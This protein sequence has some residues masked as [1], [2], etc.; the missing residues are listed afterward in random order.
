MPETPDADPKH[1]FDDVE[2][3]VSCVLLLLDQIDSVCMHIVNTGSWS[4]FS[5]EQRARLSSVHQGTRRAI[6]AIHSPHV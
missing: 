2:E 4:T 6:A 5:P 3:Q 1:L